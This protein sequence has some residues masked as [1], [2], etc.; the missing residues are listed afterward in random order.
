[1]PDGASSASTAASAWPQ[2]VWG[3]GERRRCGVETWCAYPEG[4]VVQH[5]YVRYLDSWDLVDKK[6]YD[7]DDGLRLPISIK[8]T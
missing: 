4:T 5:G 3:F 6:A 2:V 7:A 1:M 8:K